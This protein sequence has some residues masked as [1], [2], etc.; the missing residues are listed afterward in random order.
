MDTKTRNLAFALLVMVLLFWQRDTI[1]GAISAIVND[2]I[3]DSVYHTASC[4]EL[5][6]TSALNDIVSKHTDDL[7]AIKAIDPGYV[8]Y[9]INPRCSGERGD[10]TFSY[11]GNAHRKAIQ[12]MLGETFHGVPYNLSNK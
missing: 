8:F 10:I 7:E 5:P 4:D 6:T 3:Y 11:T 2:V 9:D 1:K 12:K